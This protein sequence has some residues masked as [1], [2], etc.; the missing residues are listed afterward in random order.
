MT[1]TLSLT[2]LSSWRAILISSSVHRSSIGIVFLIGSI[3]TRFSGRGADFV[4]IEDG[5]FGVDVS[6]R[7]EFLVIRRSGSGSDS[8]RSEFRVTRR[9]TVTGGITSRIKHSL[10]HA[11]R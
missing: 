2:L 9:S 11:Q 3:W 4:R 1:K 10:G 6:S 8:S 5:L 7:L